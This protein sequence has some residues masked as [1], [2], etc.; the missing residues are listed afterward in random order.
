M[1]SLSYTHR[2]EPATAANA[3]PLL[4][5]HGTGGNEH[6]LI[7]LGQQLAPGSAL[8]SPRG[9]V[10]EHGMPRFFQRFAE[11]VF[12]LADVAKRTHAL[13]DFVVASATKY[14]FE[15]SRLTALG[16]SNGANIAASL[17][18]LRP[19]ALAG[20]VLLRPMVVLEPAKLPDLR[21]KRLLLLSGR[22][23]PIVPVEHPDRLAAQLRAAGADVKLQ[24]LDTGHP[25]TDADL[26]HAARF[27]QATR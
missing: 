5:L 2:Y 11:G 17:F 19:E 15:T 7:P 26:G 6:D 16:Y 18:L 24:W 10:S 22:H 4:L 21:G 1:S 23:D 8:L 27:L 12:D 13:A 3:S 20:A 9:D 25:L 14:G